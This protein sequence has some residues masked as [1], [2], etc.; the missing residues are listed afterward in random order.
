V[1]CLTL[2]ETHTFSGRVRSAKPSLLVRYVRTLSPKLLN[3]LLGLGLRGLMAV[4]PQRAPNFPTTKLCAE[5][6]WDGPAKPPDAA[7][8]D[9]ATA[10]PDTAH[11]GL[12][13]WSSGCSNLEQRITTGEEKTMATFSVLW[14]N[15]TQNRAWRAFVLR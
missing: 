8:F 9:E 13:S 5:G 14:K 12:R 1:R 6:R 11:S 3:E 2:D 4:G 7:S 10:E 15:A